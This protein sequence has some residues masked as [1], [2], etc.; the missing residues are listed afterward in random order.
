M[1]KHF[2][3]ASLLVFSTLA[4]AQTW[5]DVVLIDQ[6]CARAKVNPDAHTADCARASANSGLG[7]ITSSGEFL[8]FDK[9]GTEQAIRLLSMSD[10]TDHLRVVVEGEQKGKTIVIS[11]I[12]FK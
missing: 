11:K 2:V 7:I 12:Q 5:D 3:L 1:T 8:K 4:I 10:K 6:S 9:K